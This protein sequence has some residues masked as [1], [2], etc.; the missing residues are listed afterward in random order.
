M[1]LTFAWTMLLFALVACGAAGP[2]DPADPVADGRRLFGLWCSGCHAV[3]A[4][5]PAGAGP[6]LAGVATRA[7]ANPDGLGAEEWLRRETVMPNAAITPG[8]QPGV[9][10]GDY[11]QRLRPE[12]IDALVAFMLTLE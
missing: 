9:M 6:N 1:R 7:A 3:E 12:Q 4:G 8:Y 10:P 2:S 5:A 11:G